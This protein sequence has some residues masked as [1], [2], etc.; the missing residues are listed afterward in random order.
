MPSDKVESGAQHNPLIVEQ[1]RVGTRNGY[2]LMEGERYGKSPVTDNWYRMSRW[3][4]R[5]DGRVKAI[6]KTE[7]DGP[8]EEVLS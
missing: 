2:P 6:Q 7:V 5:G 3:E 4:D 8:P 1:E